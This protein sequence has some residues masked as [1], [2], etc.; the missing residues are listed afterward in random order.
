MFN[1]Q[2]SVLLAKMLE[3][4]CLSTKRLVV[5]HRQIASSIESYTC[6]HLIDLQSFLGMAY[7][8]YDLLTRLSHNYHHQF[9]AK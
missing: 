7:I 4:K 8:C 5:N 2:L 9:V 6:P 1:L 3:N